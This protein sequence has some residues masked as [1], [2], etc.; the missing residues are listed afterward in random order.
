VELYGGGYE[1]GNMP[2]GFFLTLQELRYSLKEISL[3]D[4]LSC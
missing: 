3:A 2:K 1:V 4:G